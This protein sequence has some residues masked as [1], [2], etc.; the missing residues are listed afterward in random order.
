MIFNNLSIKLEDI[1]KKYEYLF[2]DE[3]REIRANLILLL[4]REEYLTQEELY[5]LYTETFEGEDEE[6]LN[7][8]LDFLCGVIIEEIKIK[9]VNSEFKAYRKSE[10]I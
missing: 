10:L 2:S 5:Q 9:S 1:K 4:D 8:E 7:Q 3:D 6:L